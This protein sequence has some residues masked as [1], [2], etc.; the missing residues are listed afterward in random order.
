MGVI[1]QEFGYIR[2]FWPKMEVI[3]KEFGS[4]IKV[5]KIIQNVFFFRLGVGG[6]SQP[7]D[8]I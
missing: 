6:L 7:E 5:I 8:T 2:N 4:L 3:C 1:F